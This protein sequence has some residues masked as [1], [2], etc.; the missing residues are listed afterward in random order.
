M[1]VRYDANE[2][3]EIIRRIT[4][5]R[6]ELLLSSLMARR[7]TEMVGMIIILAALGGL[8]GMV[9]IKKRKQQAK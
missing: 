7:A 3:A 1:G 2:H 4:Y 6:R 8:T 9:W 5:S